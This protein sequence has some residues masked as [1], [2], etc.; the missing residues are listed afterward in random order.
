MDIGIAA[1]VL[2]GFIALFCWLSNRWAAWREKE[3]HRQYW[4]KAERQ[5]QVFEGFMP[6]LEAILTDVKDRERYPVDDRFGPLFNRYYGKS[7]HAASPVEIDI[8]LKELGYPTMAEWQKER[9]E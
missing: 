2:V 8:V 1:I 6:T 5:R 7:L 9:V 3:R 4:T